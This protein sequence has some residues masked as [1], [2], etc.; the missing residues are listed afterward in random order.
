MGYDYV[1]HCLARISEEASKQAHE[2]YLVRSNCVALQLKRDGHIKGDKMIFQT[3]ELY[4]LKRMKKILP[5]Y[6]SYLYKLCLLQ[7]V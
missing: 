5:S 7:Y 4:P 1:I 3:N 2:I 6:T